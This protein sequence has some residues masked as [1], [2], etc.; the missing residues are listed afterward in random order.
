[1]PLTAGAHLG[2]YE[3]V[4]AIGEGGM[5]QVYRARDTRLNRDVALKVLPDAF[6]ADPERTARFEREAQALAA[7][8]HPNIAQ[9]YGIEQGALVMEFVAGEDLAVVIARGNPGSKDPGLHLSDALPIARQMAVALEAAHS[10]GI[11][12]RDLK[13]ANVKVLDFGLAKAGDPT[14]T[15]GSG[16]GA[17]MTSPAMTQQGLILGTAAYMSPEQA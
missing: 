1:M 12:H 11:I 17:T 10:A 2:S 14:G 7:L 13:P 3:I 15:G 16:S 9:I 4:A 8:N 6:V 5:G